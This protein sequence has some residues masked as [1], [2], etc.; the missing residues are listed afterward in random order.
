[1]VSMKPAAARRLHRLEGWLAGIGRRSRDRS[2]LVTCIFKY[3][4]YLL[5]LPPWRFSDIVHLIREKP[6]HL[7]HSIFTF[8]FTFTSPQ[9]I[10]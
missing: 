10:W 6:I 4:F 1:M 7:M 2:K 3:A 9:V 5:Y 8:A